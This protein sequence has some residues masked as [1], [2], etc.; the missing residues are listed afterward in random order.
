MGE[1]GQVANVGE[2]AM[3]GNLCDS[4]RCIGIANIG[5]ASN[6][7]SSHAFRVDVAASEEHCN[8]RL[9]PHVMYSLKA[10]VRLNATS[11]RLYRD[12]YAVRWNSSNIQM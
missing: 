9:S 1:A 7:F 12:G 11:E 4:N 6:T 8:G 10:E 3:C 5:R 2:L